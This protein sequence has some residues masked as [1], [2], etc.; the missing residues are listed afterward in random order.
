MDGSFTDAKVH[1]WLQEIAE[2]CY[3]SLHYDTPAYGGL[4]DCEIEGGGYTRSK[5]AMSQ[6]ANRAIWS[7]ED[8]RFSGLIQNKLT[9]FGIY[10][11]AIGGMLVAYAPLP[12]PKTVLTGWGYTIHEGEL[13]LSFG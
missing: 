4:G 9:H 3:V 11:T 5:V 12:E 2:N 10:N 7:L 13:A 6:P 1:E 8:A